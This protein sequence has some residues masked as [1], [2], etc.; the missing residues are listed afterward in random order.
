M[1]SIYLYKTTT[2]SENRTIRYEISNLENVNI[3]MDQ[4][5]SPMALPQEHASEN[6]LVKMEGNTETSS[7]SWKVNTISTDLIKTID[8]VLTTGQI[9]SDADGTTPNPTFNWSP[10]SEYT[11]SG[12]IV[13]YLLSSFQGFSINDRYFLKFPDMDLR[14]GFINRI[15]FSITGD[16]PV[17]WTG[18]INF[19]LGN[20]ISMYDGDTPSEPRNV[21]ASQVGSTGL[22]SDTPKT[23]IRLRW[24]SPTDTATSIVKYRVYRKSPTGS[25]FLLTNELTDSG[26]DGAVSGDTSYKEFEVTGLTSTTTYYFYITAVN[27]AG[28][29]MKSDTVVVA[30]P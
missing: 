29:G 6:V 10:L 25:K 27:D 9:T 3:T 8:E 11:E 26:L 16:S 28:S 30:F 2:F 4:P 17:I 5:V 15:S 20:V 1:G 19:I 23:S 12:E 21:S 22:T 24:T 7:I 18:I 14:E 13:S